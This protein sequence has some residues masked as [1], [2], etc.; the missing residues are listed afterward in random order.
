MEELNGKK[1]PRPRHMETLEMGE[2]IQ[3]CGYHPAGLG[4]G[5]NAVLETTV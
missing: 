4:H 3:S 5:I 2:V 1:Y